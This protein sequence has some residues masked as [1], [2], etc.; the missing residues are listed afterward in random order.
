MDKNAPH[1]GISSNE[2]IE[3]FT[4][5]YL[6]IDQTCLELKIRAIQLHQHR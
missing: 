3:F 5:K 1:C 6:T 4:D 2:D